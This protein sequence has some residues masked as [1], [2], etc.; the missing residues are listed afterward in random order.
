MHNQRQ[1][2]AHLLSKP[3]ICKP[4]TYVVAYPVN[5]FACCDTLSKP[6]HFVSV[7]GCLLH[8]WQLGAVCHKESRNPDLQKVPD[9][10]PQLC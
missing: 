10:V 4:S 5:A 3:A 6:D 7:N 9:C 2:A 1:I 8:V